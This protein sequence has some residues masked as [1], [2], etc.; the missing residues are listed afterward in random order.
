MATT[1]LRVGERK[2]TINFF[3]HLA[4]VLFACGAILSAADSP[5][6]P[7]GLIEAG[8]FKRARAIVEPILQ[9]NPNDAE[10]AYMLSEIKEAFGDLEGATTLA[11]KAVSLDAKNAHYHLQLGQLY[12]QAAQKASIFKQLGLAHKF[13]SELQTALSIDPKLLDAQEDMMEFYLQAPGIVGGDKKQAHAIAD[14]IAKINPVRG[15]LAQAR[16]AQ[17]A[18]DTSAE[19][20]ARLKAVQ[21][22]PHDYNALMALAGFY[23]R[24]ASKKPELAEKYYREALQ[25]EPSRAGAYAGLALVY[26]EQARWDDLEA[27]LGRSE[28]SIPD[29]FVG[30]YQAGRIVFLQGKDFARAERFFRKYLTQEPEGGSPNWAAAHWRL[31]LVLEKEGRKNDAIS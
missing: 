28:K 7:Q 15:F 1:R 14:E 29:N 13:K 10:A 11:E 18:K 27:I 2:S 9:K 12:G 20:A 22:D 25:I 30:F 17:E 21:T 6:S 31:G 5:E 3:L 16:L 8:H 26:G 24:P 23:T 19:E 4:C